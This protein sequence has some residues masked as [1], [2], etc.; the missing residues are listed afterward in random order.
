M[1][2]LYLCTTVY[3]YVYIVHMFVGMD[4]DSEW[5]VDYGNYS[6]MYLACFGGM[7][8]SI[9]TSKVACWQLK[10]TTASKQYRTKL[11]VATHNDCQ[12]D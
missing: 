2:D 12:L 1:A 8:P 10:H 4:F 9:V 3:M 11:H 7:V 5:I 6:T